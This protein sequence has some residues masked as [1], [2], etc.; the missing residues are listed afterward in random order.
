MIQHIANRHT[1]E[2]QVADDQLP[3][4][5]TLSNRIAPNIEPRSTHFRPYSS[6]YLLTISAME[7]KNMLLLFRTALTAPATY[8]IRSLHGTVKPMIYQS[9]E[10]LSLVEVSCLHRIMTRSIE[11]D[12]ILPSPSTMAKDERFR[13]GLISPNTYL[14]RHRPRA[15]RSQATSTVHARRSGAVCT[16]GIVAYQ[17]SLIVS[18]DLFA[19]L[20]F[21]L[22]LQTCRVQRATAWLVGTC[23][24]GW[25]QNRS[26]R[27]M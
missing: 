20:C 19:N 1:E 17:P 18:P 25:E 3:T 22:D 21:E 24:T 7:C 8:N 4:H 9:R 23:R 11:V 27:T 14:K 5:H 10:I 6:R 16:H 12:H 15:S 13:F 2:E 26:L